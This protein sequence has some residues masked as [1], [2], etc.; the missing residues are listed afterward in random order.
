MSKIFLNDKQG[1]DLWKLI[2]GKLLLQAN[3][4]GGKSWAIRRIIEQCYGKIPQIVLDTEG[5]FANLREKYDFILI[6]KGQDI[7]ANPKTAALLAHRLIEERVSAI[8]DLLEMTPYERETFVR[9][10]VQAMTNAPRK[11][12]LPTLLIVDEAQTYA[13]EGDKTECGRTLHDA[14]FKFRK[15]N[16]GILFATPRISA[17]SKNVISTCKNKLIGYSSLDNDMK[18]A[19]FE[20]GFGTREEILS[21]RNLDPGEFFVFGSAI[22]KEVLKIKIGGTKTRHGT[23]T[24]NPANTKIAPPTQ[25]VRKALARLADLPQEAEKEAT[26]IAELKTENLRLRRENRKVEKA[27]KI[28]DVDLKK[29]LE[30]YLAKIKIVEEVANNAVDALLAHIQEL[31]KIIEASYGLYKTMQIPKVKRPNASF[32]PPKFSVSI[33]VG[34]GKDKTVAVIAKHNENGITEIVSEEKLGRCEAMIYSFLFKYQDREF[35]KRQIGA[36]V[37]YSIRSSGFTNALSK[38]N[39]LDLIHREGEKIQIG[40]VEP[41]LAIYANADF[42]I[43]GWL[44]NLGK[45]PREIYEFL[46]DNPHE[47]FT[48][49]QIADATPSHYSVNSSGFTNALSALNSTGLVRREGSNIR[50]NPELLEIN[51]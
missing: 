28:T 17:L 40:K 36:A 38:L 8:I 29:I 41:S 49:E 44:N 2:S 15:R 11:L 31:N 48:K 23:E 25:K 3:T 51:Q 10:F 27:E 32:V 43:K 20:L 39:T 42:S 37:G 21:L 46:L 35:N 16:F 26:T 9:N 45:C 22:S 13:P 33:D 34:K 4:G 1:F 24:Y 12:W 7:A 6:G 19:A 47:A 30:P 50:L 5:E 18:R 14:A